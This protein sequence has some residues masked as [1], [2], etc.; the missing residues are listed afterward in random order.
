[1]ALNSC[2]PSRRS[3]P[4]PWGF[5]WGDRLEFKIADKW[6]SGTVASTRWVDWD[7]FN[8]NFFVIANPETL[9]GYPATYITSFHLAPEDRGAL[10]ELVKTWPSITVFDVASILKQVRAIMEQVAKAVE[11]VSGFTLLAGDHSP[12]G[13][14][15]NHP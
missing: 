10:I 7:T 2:F 1:M 12:A 14:A 15:A 11:F 13:R 9:D 8:V 6:V 3:S 4:I 5:P